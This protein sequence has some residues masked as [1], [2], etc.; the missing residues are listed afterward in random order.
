MTRIELLSYPIGKFEPPPFY[1]KEQLTSWINEIAALPG[2]L[3]QAVLGVKESDLEITYKP[4]GWSVKQVIHHI[5][6]SHSNSLIRFK[7]A[8]TEIE[9]V[10]RPYDQDAWANLEDYNMPVEVSLMMIEALHLHWVVLL[11]SLSEQQWSR[12][13]YHPEQ[14]KAI[15]LK[16]ATGMYAWHGNHHLAHISNAIAGL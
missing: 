12:S 6:D 1:T 9:P 3:K 15:S 13:Y 16:Q 8:L 2:R 14:L 7:L 10:I 11:N 4:G 5:A